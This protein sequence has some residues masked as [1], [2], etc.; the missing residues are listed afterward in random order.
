MSI[1]DHRSQRDPREPHLPPR[2]AELMELPRRVLALLAL[3]ILILSAGCSKEEIKAKLKEAQDKVEA[4]AESTV[5]AVEEQLPES[6]SIALQMTPAVEKTGT[7]DVELIS[8]GDGRPNVVRI[9]TYDPSTTKRTYPSVML[10]GT[11]DATSA[12]ALS[13][14][15]VECDMYFRANYDTPI[16]MTK[17]DGSV[18]VKFGAFNAEDNA[19]TATFGMAQLLGSDD[20][21]IQITGGAIVAV[22]RDEGN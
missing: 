16:A 6:G 2:D 21:S 19:L 3:G 20:K 17:P 7:A 1:F 14:E 12:P 5:E 15:T 8:I 10:Q 13:G 22:V 18:A 11:T 9:I 4:V